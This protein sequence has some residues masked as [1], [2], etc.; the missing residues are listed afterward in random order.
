MQGLSFLTS[1]GNHSLN[2]KTLVKYMLILKAQPHH[3]VKNS[4]LNPTQ[5]WVYHI[6]FSFRNY[7]NTTGV[8]TFNEQR[9]I[10]AL[11]LLKEISYPKIHTVQLNA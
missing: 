10:I 3:M 9:L 2:E 11:D 1:K 4:H 7:E 6:Y 8:L 5:F